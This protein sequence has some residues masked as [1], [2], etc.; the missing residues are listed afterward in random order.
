MAATKVNGSQWLHT[1][2][3][4]IAGEIAGSSISPKK[5][6]DLSK[7]LDAAWET[8]QDLEAK[9]KASN[10][11]FK[12][13]AEVL[14]EKFVNLY[15]ELEDGFV[16]RAVIQIQEESDLLKTGKVSHQAV[17]RL[18]NHISELENNH[19]PSIPERRVVAD[20]KHALL[21]AKAKLEGKPIVKHIDWLAK[22]QNV[23]FVEQT[24]NELLPGEV[25]E[26]FDIAKAVYKRDYRE[27]KKRYA[28]IS[29]DHQSRFI[30]HM[31]QLMAKPFE[32][33][34]ETIQAL[35]ATI[36]D[37]VGNGEGYPSKDQ[38]HQHFLGLSQ[39]SALEEKS[40]RKIISFPS[41]S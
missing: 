19:L 37:L 27:A 12:T 38:I 40:D 14:K 13:Q 29:Y 24:A 25:E 1:Q 11:F 33:E 34:I 23:R 21:E 10:L 5:Y 39:L 9:N 4:A 28:G 18:E 36:N 2:V 3:Q 6:Q 32:D 35:M 31:Q 15:K 26:L 17:N 22:Q 20:A 16:R 30:S 8:L 7:K 41:N